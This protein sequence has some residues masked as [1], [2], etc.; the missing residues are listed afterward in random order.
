MV[1][2]SRNPVTSA[3]F[4][5]TT[6]VNAAVLWMLL[7]AEFLSFTIGVNDT[8]TMDRAAQIA[9]QFNVPHFVLPFE[10]TRQ[11]I[12]GV[13]GNASTRYW[14]FEMHFKAAQYAKAHDFSCIA[15]G[16]KDD[17]VNGDLENLLYSVMDHNKF[18]GR[19]I[20]LR[21]LRKTTS[22]EEVEQLLEQHRQN[23]S[24]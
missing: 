22:K 13:R 1:V 14:N 10:Q 24:T 19:V 3:L 17:V 2:L 12:E 11:H 15:S 23:K 18:S 20:I 7:N 9:Q 5:V 16:L 4:L 21:P 6:F 8:E